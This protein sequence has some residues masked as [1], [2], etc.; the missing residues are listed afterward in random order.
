MDFRGLP[1]SPRAARPGA[2][3]G[4]PRPWRPPGRPSPR[5][6]EPAVSSARPSLG[7]RPGA[8]ASGPSA[9]GHRRGGGREREERDHD[10]SGART[11]G[12]T[13]AALATAA[14]LSGCEPQATPAQIR[15][16]G[17][18]PV[19]P[20]HRPDRPDGDRPGD[21]GG[22]GDS[23]RSAD[24]RR[25]RR[26]AGRFRTGA[27]EIASRVPVVTL[28]RSRGDD[29]RGGRLC[30]DGTPAVGARQRTGCDH[31]AHVLAG[32]VA[33]TRRLVRASAW[34]PRT[35]CAAWPAARNQN[36]KANLAPAPKLRTVV[37]S[38]RT[39]RTALDTA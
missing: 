4:W 23:R 17:P 15:S 11:V 5:R 12:L 30:A 25:G 27:Q 33:R 36:G 2:G 13:L 10:P 7:G 1:R 31:S 37:K 35:T 6:P 20:E 18:E 39:N 32:A 8:G 22:A 24:R 16:A 21:S 14:A 28:H 34:W 38:P 19:D 3:S 9:L 26:G 29:P